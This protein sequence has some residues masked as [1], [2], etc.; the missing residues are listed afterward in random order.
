MNYVVSYPQDHDLGG[1]DQG[2]RSLA[3]LEIHFAGRTRGDDGGD[4]LIADGNLDLRHQAADADAV[5]SAYELISPAHAAGYQ[6]PFGSILS[7][8][9]V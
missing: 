6:S 1:F 7:R 8:R 2:S 3:W 9:P 5:D 4:L